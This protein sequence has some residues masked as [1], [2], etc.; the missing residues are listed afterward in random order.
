MLIF[1]KFI[2]ENKKTEIDKKIAVFFQIHL[3]NSLEKALEGTS[4]TIRTF[5]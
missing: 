2:D 1:S 4:T 3:E 5:F